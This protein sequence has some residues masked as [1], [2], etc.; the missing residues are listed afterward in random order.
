M[1]HRQEEEEEEGERFSGE[2]GN[3]GLTVSDSATA[4]AASAASY[5]DND[6]STHQQHTQAMDTA[7]ER[8]MPRIFE[9]A[10]RLVPIAAREL[11]RGLLVSQGGS[12][13][14]GSVD[15]RVNTDNEESQENS[16]NHDHDIEVGLSLP[17]DVALAAAGSYE[18]SLDLESYPFNDVVPVDVIAASLDS[19][20]ALLDFEA[21]ALLESIRSTS[22]RNTA[23]GDGGAVGLR[24]DDDDDDDHNSTT[25]FSTNED[26]DGMGGEIR[27]LGQVVASLR[28]DL[29]GAQGSIQIPLG[30]DEDGR[31]SH[32]SRRVN[33][34]EVT[35]Y[36]AQQLQSYKYFGL[37]SDGITSGSQYAALIWVVALVW[38]LIILLSAHV[39]LGSDIDGSASWIDVICSLFS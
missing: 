14:S 27:R 2:D 38:A 1:E 28:R 37:G 29:A 11:E 6:R 10:E 26:D 19:D 8:A 7:R 4:T 23:G 20:V 13:T 18:Y 34:G 15:G 5:A 35:S 9:L 12:L 31:G 33:R 17:R 39:Q 25:F 30:D 24:D 16:N 22:M 32:S 21:D 36:L 3:G